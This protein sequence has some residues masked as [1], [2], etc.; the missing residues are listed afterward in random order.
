[1]ASPFFAGKG[2]EGGGQV[3]SRN[4]PTSNNIVSVGYAWL[5]PRRVKRKRKEPAEGGR[6]REG[7]A[8]RGGEIEGRR[9]KR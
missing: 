1:M 6:G 3:L 5:R 9:E 7:N 4:S 8:G 2:R